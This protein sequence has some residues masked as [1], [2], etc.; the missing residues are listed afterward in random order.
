MN[1]FSKEKVKLYSWGSPDC[2]GK[3][4][5]II[6]VVSL[7]PREMLKVL[8]A[9]IWWRGG[10]TLRIFYLW[11]GLCRVYYTISWCDT[12]PNDNILPT[13]RYS[14]LSLECAMSDRWHFWLVS[15]IFAPLSLPPA[16]PW[17]LRTI[18]CCVTKILS[19]LLKISFSLDNLD[20]I[21]NHKNENN[22][23]PAMIWT[24]KLHKE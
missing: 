10:G 13:T 21:L 17:L 22:T 4:Y 19:R 7:R 14:L 3:L 9:G 20:G 23:A 2:P 18:K 12:D 15:H 8:L 1:T 24:A 5:C 11:S 16:T 6:R